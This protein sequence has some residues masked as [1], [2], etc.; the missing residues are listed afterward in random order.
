MDVFKYGSE[1]TDH[2][3][4]AGDSDVW[5]KVESEVWTCTAGTDAAAGEYWDTAALCAAECV[6]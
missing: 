4:I 3:K 1:G 6:V 5:V 2:G